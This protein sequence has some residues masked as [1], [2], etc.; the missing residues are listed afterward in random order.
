MPDREKVL[1]GLG[2]CRPPYLCNTCPYCK[3]DCIGEKRLHQDVLELIK[4]QEAEIERLKGELHKF[5]DLFHALSEKT[6]KAMEE[7]P[8]IVQ[9]KDCVNRGNAQ[10]CPVAYIE[11][12]NEYKLIGLDDW[13]CGNGK[14]DGERE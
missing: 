13:F 12:E 14:K 7:Q 1:Y 4:E 11:K 5:G 6:E 2:C 3:D 9:C 8:N 10:T